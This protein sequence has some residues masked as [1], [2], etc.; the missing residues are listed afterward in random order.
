MGRLRLAWR[1][2]A[3]HDGEMKFV[4]RFLL[5]LGFALAW[6]PA[7]TAATPSF[8]DA[9]SGLR[10]ALVIGNGAYKVAPLDN[11]VR[12][13]RL[14]AE[15]L[16]AVRFRVTKLENATQEQMLQA[17]VDLGNEVRKGGVGLFYYAGHGVQLRG[18]NYLIPVDARIDREEAIRSRAVNAQEVI[19]R[20]AAAGNPLNLVFLDACRSDPFPR[21]TR[22]A[23]QGL[24]KMDATLGML[25]S[26][27]TAPGNVAED[28]TGRNSPYSRHL[29]ETM[30]LPGLRIEDVLKRVRT[31]VREETGG[32][33]ITWDNSSIEGDFY[34]LP[35]AAAAARPAD[36][37]AKA[38]SPVRPPAAA[39]GKASTA[40]TSAPER[41][42]AP[43]AQSISRPPPSVVTAG[44][45]APGDTWTYRL[46]SRWSN[47]GER[48]VV[49]RAIASSDG[50]VRDRLGLESAKG[51]GSEASFGAEAAVVD[52]PASG[53]TVAELNPYLLSF[54]RLEP[55][56]RWDAVPIPDVPGT[57]TPWNGRAR[58]VA[59]ETIQTAA[60]GFETLRI[61]LDAHRTIIGGSVPL[62]T[63]P[64]RIDQTFW[65]APQ[66][67]RL[68]R[69][70]R[71]VFTGNG[72][73]LDDDAFEL[74]RF[75]LR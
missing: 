14:M 44:L 49:V 58:V 52:R 4:F 68:V 48:I 25:I 8:A 36:G 13:A 22:T 63:E 11:P 21:S 24:A 26:F 53:T 74:V 15:A 64:A 67:K 9:G 60:G 69:Y 10:V 39:P 51:P 28:G 73:L 41:P 2:A 16:A 50:T 55:G 42:V 46:R 66:A 54:W 30:R 57:A 72:R 37:P 45:P 43:V 6:A 34:F 70:Q 5:L 61:Q 40:P 29:A 32:R 3:H 38:P 17:I 56:R 62:T 12:D 33:Q 65:Y 59:R 23:A 1:P 18:E 71:K 35:P 47:V 7:L 19:D 31:R 75:D 27:A 20:L